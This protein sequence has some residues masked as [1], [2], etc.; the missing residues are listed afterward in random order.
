M[1]AEMHRA[2]AAVEVKNLWKVYGHV[3][4]LK[5]VDLTVAEGSFLTIF[6]PNGAGKTTLMK[7]LATLARPT[8]GSALVGGHDVTREAGAVRK[9]VGVISHNTYLYPQ[10]TAMENL[11]FY[12]RMYGLK[13]A[14]ERSTQLLEQLGLATRMH[15]RVATFS[16]GMQQRLSVARA[17]L[18]E[19]ELLL[20]DEP[21]TGLD[22]HASRILAGVLEGL[23]DGQ[24]T[25]VMTTHNL[26]EG[27]E[28]C[29]RVA[30][31]ARGRM[32]FEE[33]AAEVDRSGFQATYFACVERA[34]GR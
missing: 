15:D 19:P 9:R 33:A 6:G 1:L 13:R 32:V 7:V 26:Q 10:L 4:A 16:R 17:L 34:W 27:L 31:L 22:Q 29:D 24:R 11:A 25:V 2:V 28:S 3:E 12:G 18:H 21:Y 5:G 23:R 14:R 8:D 30:I 20:L